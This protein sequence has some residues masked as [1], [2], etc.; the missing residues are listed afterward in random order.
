MG[1]GRSRDKAEHFLAIQRYYHWYD[2]ASGRDLEIETE[3][4]EELR[5][6]FESRN[7]SISE[8]EGEKLLQDFDRAAEIGCMRVSRLLEVC[9]ALD[10]PPKYLEGIAFFQRKYPI[11]LDQPEIYKLISHILNEGNARITTD[12]KFHVVYNNLDPS[13]NDRVA[14]LAEA[15]GGRWARRIGKDNVPETR[16]D[17]TTARALMKVGLVPGA[18]TTGQYL[19][20]LPG[21]IREDGALSRYHL[22][23]TFTEEGWPSIT[24][25]E[26][27]RPGFL[28]AYSRSVDITDTLPAEYVKS[29]QVSKKVTARKMPEEI[30]SVVQFTPFPLLQDE[31]R[32][33]ERTI[34]EH[35]RINFVG[36][37]K[38]KDEH[39]TA[40]WRVTLSTHEQVEEFRQ[41][42]GFL[43][44]SDVNRRFEKMWKIYQENRDKRLTLEDI[45]AIRE[46]LRKL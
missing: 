10:V 6:E 34:G 30:R 4:L 16:L 39:V 23:A 13:L 45:E 46:R 40:E 28:V 33:S 25:H 11:P 18:K 15:L 20:P 24:L 43:P 14:S 5:R 19:Q 42:I 21:P 9:K 31:V 32:M 44:E 22:S 41:K 7:L 36:L 3:R 1:K 35:V 8:G 26:G 2:E 38:S 27:I 17:A 29:M 37:Y 12:G